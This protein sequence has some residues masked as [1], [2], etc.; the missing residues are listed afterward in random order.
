MIGK[1]LS[2]VKYSKRTVQKS[3]PSTL[4]CRAIARHPRPTLS[5]RAL[6][7][8]PHFVRDGVLK[9]TPQLALGVTASH[10]LIPNWELLVTLLFIITETF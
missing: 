7:G 10:R 5:C 2:D 3:P 6:R 4:S 9:E 1:F 8:I